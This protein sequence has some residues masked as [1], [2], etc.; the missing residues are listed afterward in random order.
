[1]TASVLD[2]VRVEV[3]LN[4]EAWR[5]RLLSPNALAKLA[6]DL[7]LGWFSASDITGLWKLGLHSK[8]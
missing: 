5:R 6:K 3:V 2:Q 4:F 7:G 1:M 8:I